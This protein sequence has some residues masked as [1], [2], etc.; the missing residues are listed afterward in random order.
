LK[1]HVARVCFNYFRCFRGMVQ[2][3]HMDVAKIDCLYMLQ[4]LYTYIAS[5][6]F[7]CLFAFSDICCKCRVLIVGIPN[8]GQ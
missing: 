7:K 2:V 6:R 8:Q 4:W 3:F 5:V 1:E